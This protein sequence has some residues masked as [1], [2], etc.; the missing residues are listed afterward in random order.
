MKNFIK[1]VLTVIMIIAALI[2]LYIMLLYPKHKYPDMSSIDKE[3]TIK[4][5]IYN[6]IPKEFGGKDN[7]LTAEL[8]I[9]SVQLK[10]LILN[11]IKKDEG[12]ENIDVIIENNNIKVYAIKKYFGLI[13]IEIQGNVDI[14]SE[15]YKY[16]LVFNEI[17][18]GKMQFGVSSTLDEIKKMEIPFMDVRP[19][20]NEII[21]EDNEL[22]DSITIDSVVGENGNL[23]AELS[24]KFNNLEDFLNV[25]NIL[26]KI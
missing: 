26:S 16:K 8:N 23:K 21:L 9:S 20:A 6:A 13:P 25:I 1:F 2:I 5:L 4:S 19:T 18:V 10:S 3:M 7:K 17:V 12:I 11:N 24:I 22:K 15:D 14:K